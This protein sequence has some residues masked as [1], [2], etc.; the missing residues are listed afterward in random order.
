MSKNGSNTKRTGHHKRL[1]APP[2]F[3]TNFNPY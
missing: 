3:Y 1:K 2:A